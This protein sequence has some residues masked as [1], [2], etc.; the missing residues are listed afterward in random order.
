MKIPKK[1]SFILPIFL[2]LTGCK[3]VNG[4]DSQTDVFAPPEPTVMERELNIKEK[5]ALMD[6]VIEAL[7]SLKESNFATRQVFENEGESLVHTIEGKVILYT[8]NDFWV[9]QVERQTYKDGLQEITVEETNGQYY[10]NDDDYIYFIE[11][12]PDYYAFYSAPQPEEPDLVYMQALPDF[13]TVDN[14]ILLGEDG[15]YY[16]IEINTDTDYFLVQSDPTIY[17]HEVIQTTSIVKI[18]PN[19][20][21]ERYYA[22]GE[23]YYLYTNSNLTPNIKDM[24]CETKGVSHSSYTYGKLQAMPG[25]ADKIANFPKY[26]FVL[27]EPV[28][29]IYPVEIDGETGNP[30]VG[31]Y[32]DRYA[33][34]IDNPDSI[35]TFRGNIDGSFDGHVY[36]SNLR[37]SKNEALLVGIIEYYLEVL[38]SAFGVDASILDDPTGV[39]ELG[40][41]LLTLDEYHWFVYFADDEAP[42]NIYVDIEISFHLKASVVDE[43]VT[44]TCDVSKFAI[45]PSKH[46]GME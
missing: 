22:E 44:I 41:T 16:C 1:L 29:W 45:T 32:A 9:E 31:E 27:I 2:L 39:E 19:Y 25:K 42:N 14:T 3:G 5:I 46:Y 34:F 4:K 7:K 13:L 30:V 15:N 10:F 20:Q 28:A 23:T 36:I 26:F 33:S 40:L 43:V 12:I 6:G 24:M 8:E 37:I 11:Y 38:T 17:Y 18:K 35:L 21:I